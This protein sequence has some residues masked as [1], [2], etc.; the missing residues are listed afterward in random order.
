VMTEGNV[1]VAIERLR[2]NKV[3]YRAVLSR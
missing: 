1:N 3:R 2:E